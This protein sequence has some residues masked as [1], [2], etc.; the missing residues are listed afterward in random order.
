[1][2]DR[3]KIF[4]L[5]YGPL[6]PRRQVQALILSFFP[7]QFSSVFDEVSKTRSLGEFLADF[8]WQ[9]L[10]AAQSCLWIDLL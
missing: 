10:A 3:P 7:F 1:M 4:S 6:E 8:I 5:R 2:D 9:A